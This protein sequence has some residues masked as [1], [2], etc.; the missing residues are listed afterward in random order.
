VDLFYLLKVLSQHSNLMSLLHQAGLSASG[1]A[2]AQ[3][4]A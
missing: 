4:L 2:A 3:S 1:V